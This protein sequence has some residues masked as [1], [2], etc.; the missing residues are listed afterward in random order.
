MLLVM[1]IE[2]KFWELVLFEPEVRTGL[3]IELG[4]LPVAA[5]V[6]VEQQ[7]VSLEGW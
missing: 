2:V 5:T 7:P 3:M 6:L 1:K 4:A